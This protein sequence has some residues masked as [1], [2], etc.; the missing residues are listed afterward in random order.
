MA[1]LSRGLPYCKQIVIPRHIVLFRHC[2]ARTIRRRFR[3]TASQ[4][5]VDLTLPDQVGSKS[6]TGVSNRDL[7]AIVGFSLGSHYTKPI[8]LKLLLDS[9]LDS[10]H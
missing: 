9:F 10:R 8:L 2:Q 3:R 6:A 7:C 4:L 1:S 5:S